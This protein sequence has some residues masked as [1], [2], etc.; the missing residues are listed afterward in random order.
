MND[1]HSKL[2]AFLVE[3]TTKGVRKQLKGFT[4]QIKNEIDYYAH[5]IKHEREEFERLVEATQ[6][7]RR[8]LSAI[9]MMIDETKRQSRLLA[10]MKVCYSDMKNEMMDMQLSMV[11][12]ARKMESYEQRK[13][14]KNDGRGKGLPD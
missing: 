2:I 8:D 3:K 6:R 12:H 11:E 13:G 7:I 14:V 9:E 5:R 1:D 10:E 4:T